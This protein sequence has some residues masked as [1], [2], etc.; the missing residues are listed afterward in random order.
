MRVSL[1]RST[2][3]VELSLGSGWTVRLMMT[4]TRLVGKRF[5]EGDTSSAPL[6]LSFLEE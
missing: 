5:I 1:S 2:S 4:V 3:A 6:K